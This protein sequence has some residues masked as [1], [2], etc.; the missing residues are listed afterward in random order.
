MKTPRLL[1]LTSFISLGFA[2]CAHQNYGSAASLS[3]GVIVTNP[4]SQPT[5]SGTGYLD[6]VW[7][8]SQA[9]LNPRPSLWWINAASPQPI[10]K[11]HFPMAA[12]PSTVTFGPL[13]GYIAPAAQPIRIW[14][15]QTTTLTV[16]YG[17]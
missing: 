9:G 2:G 1:L 5:G 3:P 8:S 11:T 14:R 10:N 15:G 16:C 13:A 7:T 6:V 4:T 17:Q 12:G